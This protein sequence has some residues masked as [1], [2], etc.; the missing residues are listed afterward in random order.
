MD[1]ITKERLD[2]LGSAKTRCEHSCIKVGHVNPCPDRAWVR[3]KYM[4][5]LAARV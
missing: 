2:G 3:M 1:S 5:R 4:K